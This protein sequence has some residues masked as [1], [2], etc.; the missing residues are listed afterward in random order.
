M[1]EEYARKRKF[2]R[3]P[4]PPPSLEEKGE[5]SAGAPIFC[6]QRHDATRL[7][8]DFRLE[9]DGVLK[10]WAIP[11]GPSL[12]PGVRHLAARVEDHPLEYGSFEGN[13]PAGEYGAG[14]VM[15][16]DRGAYELLDSGVSANEQLARGDFKFRLSGEK[17]HGDF[18]LVLMKGRGKGNEWLL[19]KKRDRF[20]IPG[21][22]IEDYAWSVI[23]GRTQEEI[24]QNMPARKAKRRTAGNPD[25]VWE[26]NR[27]AARAK[28]TRTKTAAVQATP[29]AVSKTR[30]THFDPSALKGARAAPLPDWFEP[31]SAG[32][33]VHAPAGEDWLFEVKW[34]GVRALC[35]IDGEE[36]RIYSRSGRRTERQYP[37]LSVLPHFVKARQAILDGEITVLDSKGVSRFELI[38]PRIANTDPAAV[39]HLARSAPAV[40]FLFDILYLDGYDLRDVALLDRRRA[41]ESVLMPSPVLRVSEAFPGAGEE[42]LAAARENGLEGIVAKLASSHYESR[43]SREWLKVKLVNEQEFLICGFT[44]GERDHLGALVL[45]LHEDSQ[46]VW[47]G[48]VGTGFT[49]QTLRDLRARLDPLITKRS[50]FEAGSQPPTR[51]VTWVRPELV[52]MI[53]FSNWT[54]GKHLRAPVFL[55][56]RDDVHPPAVRRESPS[57]L[58]SGTENE[59]SLSID[60]HRLKLTNLNKVLF[61]GDRYTKRDLLNYYDAVAHLILP[62]LRDRPLSLKRYPNGIDAA[63][64]FQKDMPANQGSWLRK[65]KIWSE[66]TQGPTNYVFADDRASLLYLTNLGCIDQNPWM[67]RVDSIDN[68]DFVLIDLDP[69]ECSYDKIVEAALLVRKVLDSIG[70]IGYPKT[71]GGDGMHIYIPLEPIYTYENSRMFAELLARMVIAERPELFTTPRSVAH[72]EKNRVYFDYLQNSKSKTIAAPYSARAYPH[73]PVSTPLHWRE[74]KKG[75]HPTQ[76]TIRN[77]P[78]RFARTGDLFEG[79]LGKPQQIQAALE[80]LEKLAPSRNQVTSGHNRRSA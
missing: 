23:S 26:S 17:L 34:D 37:E 2:S 72:R 49:E 55:G 28:K 4:E 77:A 39:A 44:E 71:T 52:A 9:V 51:G 63:Y 22:N 59:V 19:I 30:K 11:K 74:V 20:A 31:M 45:G 12:D 35:F 73:A 5:S 78:D 61:P 32:V 60:A 25:R 14:S 62:H 54:T 57:S 56:L 24:A 80:R 48:N 58:L 7:H 6:V 1:L 53:K 18:A 29:R 41:L 3:S 40:L 68:P 79:V 47:A 66:H 21:W 36:L 13:I 10:S 27:P 42:L 33:A 76:F 65:V 46:L 15:L 64:F 8:Y 43:R 69:Y 38:Q 75:L 67:S 50:P 16:W 70:L